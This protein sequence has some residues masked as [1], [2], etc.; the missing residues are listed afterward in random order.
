MMKKRNPASL[1]MKRTLTSQIPSTHQKIAMFLDMKGVRKG[2]QY[3]LM[4]PTFTS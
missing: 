4:Q 3:H 2:D 1:I